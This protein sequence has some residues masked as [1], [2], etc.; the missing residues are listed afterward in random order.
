MTSTTIPT[1][2]GSEAAA[3]SGVTLRTLDRGE[4]AVVLAVFAGMGPR[5]RALRFLAPKPRLTG[6]DVRRLAAVDQHDH[7]AVLASS[8]HDGLPV[9]IARFIRDRDVPQSAELALDVVDQWQGRGVGTLLLDAIVRRAVALGVR[10]ATV[11]VSSDNVAVLRLLARFP[12]GAVSS[13]GVER[14][15]AEYAVSLTAPS[16]TEV[17]T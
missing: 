4:A 14:G 16:W 10:R 7:V 11:L 3:S 6:G 1:G 9:G 5:S 12:G 15:V 8:A 2:L 17:S 13:V